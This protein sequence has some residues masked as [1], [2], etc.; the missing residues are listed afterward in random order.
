MTGLQTLSSWS[1]RTYVSECHADGGSDVWLASHQSTD[2]QWWLGWHSPKCPSQRDQTQ[3]YEW[4]LIGAELRG[5]QD[6]SLFESYIAYPNPA[7][8]RIGHD[9]TLRGYTHHV[10][11]REGA[12]FCERTSDDTRVFELAM[13][14]LMT[15]SEP[16]SK[17]EGQDR[18]SWV[19]M[20]HDKGIRKG[21]EAPY[22]LNEHFLLSGSD[23]EWIPLQHHLQPR[24]AILETKGKGFKGKGQ[25][26]G[27][28]TL[29]PKGKGKGNHQSKR[30][31]RGKAKH[32]QGKGKASDYYDLYQ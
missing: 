12:R 17:G 25:G 31:P 27:C 29:P 32:A 11:D 22:S 3:P 23:E 16:M 18:D 1:V 4:H 24:D 9:L 14:F 6:L 21:E 15:C 19:A 7:V 20:A 10:Y 2:W 8:A 13:A 26:M 30:L 5:I 28:A